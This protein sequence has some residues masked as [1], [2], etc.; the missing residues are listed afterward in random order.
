MKAK[1]LPRVKDEFDP[2]P[3]EPGADKGFGEEVGA[4]CAEDHEKGKTTQDP[5]GPSMASLADF[6]KV[7]ADLKALGIGEE[8]VW[9]SIHRYTADTF[10]KAVVEVSEFTTGEL[11]AVNGFLHRKKKATEADRAKKAKAN[12]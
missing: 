3:D 12:G 1:P 10:K 5:D 2:G 6:G 7:M 8:A 4:E 9:T 11:D